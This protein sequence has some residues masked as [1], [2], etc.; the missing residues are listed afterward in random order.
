[1]YCA[2]LREGLLVRLDPAVGTHL[3]LRVRP[4]PTEMY[5]WRRGA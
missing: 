5:C 2:L 3:D 4:D 1:M